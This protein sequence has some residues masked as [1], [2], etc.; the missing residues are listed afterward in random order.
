MGQSSTVFSFKII[1]DVIQAFF[2]ESMAAIKA[3][4]SIFS[5][6]LVW[7]PDIDQHRLS[8]FQSTSVWKN[9]RERERERSGE[10]KG[11]VYVPTEMVHF[12][13]AVKSLVVLD[14]TYTFRIR[15]LSVRNCCQHNPTAWAS[16]SHSPSLPPNQQAPLFIR[17]CYCW[18]AFRNE[19]T[20]EPG[21][22]GASKVKSAKGLGGRGLRE[23]EE[24]EFLSFPTGVFQIPQATAPRMC[25]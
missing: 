3:E 2:Y 16:N 13:A 5:S 19:K 7:F 1:V 6:V 9:D 25:E 23:N 17:A 15:G 24:Q 4:N 11:C 12:K 21:C 20:Q 22:A 14:V 18:A 10:M 8:G